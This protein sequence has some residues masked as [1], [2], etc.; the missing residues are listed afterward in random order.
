MGA[1]ENG[2]TR[3]WEYERM[4]ARENG[5]TRKWDLERLHYILVASFSS[6]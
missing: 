4:G 2:S 6:S 5:S 1:R 3:E